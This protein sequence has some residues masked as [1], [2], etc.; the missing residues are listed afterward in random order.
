MHSAAKYDA[1]QRQTPE[2][3]SALAIG[4]HRTD[5]S[6]KALTANGSGCEVETAPLVVNARLAQ[7]RALLRRTCSC[8]L[9]NSSASM[10]ISSLYSIR[11]LRWYA[12]GGALEATRALDAAEEG[13]YPYLGRRVAWAT[14]LRTRA[15]SEDMVCRALRG[16]QACPTVAFWRDGR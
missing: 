1:T 5:G 11:M 2:E 13:A 12:Y 14:V 15:V 16:Q 4:Q 8:M 6:S 9:Q 10:Y 3:L 7:A